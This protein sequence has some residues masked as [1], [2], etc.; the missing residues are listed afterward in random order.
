M[1]ATISQ[2]NG[3]Q[4]WLAVRLVSEPRCAFVTSHLVVGADLPTKISGEIVR[5]DSVTEAMAVIERGGTAVLPAGRWDLAEAVLLGFGASP[6]HASWQ[7]ASSK[8][9]VPVSDEPEVSF[10]SPTVVSIQPTSD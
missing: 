2:G 9:K 1:L 8:G 3:R 6:E 7:I 4:L 5:V 10:S